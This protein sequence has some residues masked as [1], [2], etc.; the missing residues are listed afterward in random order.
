M[1]Q[2]NQTEYYSPDRRFLLGIVTW[3]EEPG[4]W[5]FEIEPWD[6]MTAD[7]IARSYEVHA[8]NMYFGDELYFHPS[9]EAVEVESA[10]LPDSV[11]I[12]T[13]DELF[14]ALITEVADDLIL[15]LGD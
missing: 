9:S 14:N 3:Y 4:V 10:K 1:A 12:I 7:M 13:T 6:T 2:F 8:Q 11:P 15:N 5:V